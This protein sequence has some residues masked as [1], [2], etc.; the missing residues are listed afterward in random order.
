MTARD[1]ATATTGGNVGS[2]P[3]S[4]FVDASTT[5]NLHLTP[6]AADAIDRAGTLSTPIA[7]DLDGA[8]RAGLPDTGAVEFAGVPFAVSAPSEIT[9]GQPLAATWSA[10]AAFVTSADWLGLFTVGAS[11]A[12]PVDKQFTGAQPAGTLSFVA[13][14]AAG[15]YE[16]RYFNDASQLRVAMSGAITVSAA[17]APPVPPPAPAESTPPTVVIRLPTQNQQITG[18]VGV[19]VDATDDVKVTAV[20]LLI[21]GVLKQTLRTAPFKFG[22]DARNE[23]A[24]DH[25]IQIRA[26]D[27]AGNSTLSAVVHVVK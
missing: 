16:L 17:P 2:A 13:P 12:A 23:S 8:A 3:L 24:G 1:G 11:D 15:S 19:A 4:F 14:S 22:W 6:R 5:G 9:A 10:D 26:Y 7:W 21:D 20:D 25:T 18:L 27:A